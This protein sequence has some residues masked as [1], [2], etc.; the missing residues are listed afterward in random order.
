MNLKIIQRGNVT[1]SK[2]K[3]DSCDKCKTKFEYDQS[4]IQ[5]DRDGRY[6]VCPMC[7]AFI[8]VDR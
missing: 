6:V 4:D 1:E 5:R 3:I 7:G 2:P 8:S